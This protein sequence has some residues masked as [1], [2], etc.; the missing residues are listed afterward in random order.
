VWEGTQEDIMVGIGIIGCG[1]WG[2]NYIRNFNEIPDSNV[3]WCCDIDS[4]RLESIKQRFPNIR[5]TTQY[6]DILNDGYVNAVV[7]ATPAS[8]HYQITKACLL[9][10]KHVLVEKPM[11]TSVE[12]AEHL[13][14]IAEECQRVLMVGHIFLFNSG[15]RKMKEYITSGDFGEI[16][17]LYSTRTNLGPVRHDVNVVWDL[18]PHDVSIF[19]YLL[20]KLPLR[21]SATGVKALKN[22]NHD[23]AFITLIYPNGIVANIHVSWLDPNKVRELAVVGS[24]KRIVFNDL[25]NQD[26]IRI[27]EKG[28]APISQPNNYGDF[29]RISVRDGDIISP[30]I[31][32]SEPL[33]NQCQHFLDCILNNHS[34]LTD[35]RNGRDIVKILSAIQTSLAKDG[36][37]V[38]V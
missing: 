22:D 32:I 11:T 33:R 26:I 10:G 8:T 27:F 38:E 25:N 2:P 15:I 30:K 4:S 18:A 34:P 28:I 9:S 14:Q 24:K 6:E 23:V 5:V 12:S 1:H 13:I 16:Y 17:Y 35:V 29:L 7:V 21:V 3:L 36:L 37:A 31:D 19:G 20:D